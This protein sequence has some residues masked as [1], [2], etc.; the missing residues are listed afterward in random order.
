MNYKKLITL[1]SMAILVGSTILACSK[2]EPKPKKEENTN[3][4]SG[5]TKK[6]NNPTNPTN[7]NPNDPLPALREGEVRVAVPQAGG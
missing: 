7:P 6:P 3:G 4:H 1:C 2:T 5:A